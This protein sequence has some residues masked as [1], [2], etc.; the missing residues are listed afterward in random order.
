MP[1]SWTTEQENR[2]LGFLA[3][4]G[5]ATVLEIAIEVGIEIGNAE[6]MLAGMIRDDIV[7]MIPT[8]QIKPL[9][10]AA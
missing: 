7:D 9:V 2:A 4:H 5:P 8:Y 3:E 1:C 10:K 6:R